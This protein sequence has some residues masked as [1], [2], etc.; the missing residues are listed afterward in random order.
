[1]MGSRFSLLALVILSFLVSYNEILEAKSS[2]RLA[3][4]DEEQDS[5]ADR[6]Y[7]SQKNGRYGRS[8][9]RSEKVN[10]YSDEGNYR[11]SRRTPAHDSNDERSYRG[12]RRP[13]S[14]P[15]LERAKFGVTK[16]FFGNGDNSFS[17]VV[18]ACLGFSKDSIQTLGYGVTASYHLFDQSVA[19]ARVDFNATYAL[20]A[21]LSA[22]GG[23][24][25]N[26]FLGQ[27]MSNVQPGLGYQ[28]GADYRIDSKWG[29]QANYLNLK[30]SSLNGR[31]SS[32]F[33]AT[34]LEVSA[35]IN[36]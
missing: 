13:A 12:G 2:Y 8:N 33:E 17:Q 14:A 7:R 4:R 34:G 28:I 20:N 1:M 5:A 11:V 6:S 27:N 31:V 29:V 30:G 10:Q 16:A 3:H 15:S 22:F 18:G 24:N 32:D 9:R 21:Q 35:Y 23:L 19:A 26:Q 36:F 25:Y